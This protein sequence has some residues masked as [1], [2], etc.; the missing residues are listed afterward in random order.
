M[1]AEYVF[2]NIIAKKANRL[3]DSETNGEGRGGH[4]EAK[5]QSSTD[6]ADSNSRNT[7]YT[8]ERLSSDLADYLRSIRAECEHMDGKKGAVVMNCNPFTLGHRYLIETAAAEVDRLYVFV[9]SE[10]RSEFLFEDRMKMVR[11]GAGHV[12]NAIV[13]PS[14]KLIISTDTFPGYFDSRDNPS[15]N[16]DTTT[17]LRIFAEH[18]APALDISVRFVGHEPYSPVTRQY[19]RDMKEY[20]PQHGIEVREIQRMKSGETFISAS[21]VRRLLRDGRWDDIARLVPESTLKCLCEMNGFGQF[22]Q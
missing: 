22:T 15:M 10:D 12:K 4:P 8:Q 11:L 16:V 6:R 13:I 9:V 1:I 17:D 3:P 14:G 21:E 20:L 18:I 19:N 2:E 7:L 5:K